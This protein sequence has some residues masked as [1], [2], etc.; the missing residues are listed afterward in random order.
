MAGTSQGGQ[1][2]GMLV[3]GEAYGRRKR[4]GVGRM[5]EQRLR[6]KNIDR[7]CGINGSMMRVEGL[8]E[9]VIGDGE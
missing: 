8:A 1:E 5:M 6:Q 7:S 9:C 2:R 4:G 3:G